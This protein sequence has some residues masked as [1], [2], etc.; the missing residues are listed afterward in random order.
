MNIKLS[1]SAID[2]ETRTHNQAQDTNKLKPS[3]HLSASPI[4]L[5][6]VLTDLS[7]YE[8]PVT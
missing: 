8:K 3:L 4:A 6:I 2:L 1:L 5:S 7:D